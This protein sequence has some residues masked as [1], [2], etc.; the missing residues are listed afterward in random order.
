[1]KAIGLLKHNPTIFD[2]ISPKF[3]KIFMVTCMISL[4]IICFVQI[5]NLSLNFKDHRG[6][7]HPQHLQ[8][9]LQTSHKYEKPLRQDG[10]SI[11]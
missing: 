9:S 6:I 7:S 3:I 10:L 5:I 1:M 2:V 11:R 4:I 8:Q